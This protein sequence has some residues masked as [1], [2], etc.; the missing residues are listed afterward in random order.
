MEQVITSGYKPTM[1][2]VIRVERSTKQPLICYHNGRVIGDRQ[3]IDRDVIECY[4]TK[5]RYHGS[6]SLEYYYTETY[7]C[8]DKALAESLFN[9]YIKDWEGYSVPRLRQRLI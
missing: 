9:E 2:I 5:E 6:M 3:V 8:K 4:F 1:N 7:P